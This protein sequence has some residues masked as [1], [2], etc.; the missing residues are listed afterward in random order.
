MVSLDKSLFNFENA[1][2]GKALHPLRGGP[3]G[4]YQ[5]PF[6]EN[7]LCRFVHLKVQ[8]FFSVI[9]VVVFN[10]CI[11]KNIFYH[12]KLQTVVFGHQKNVL[13]MLASFICEHILKTGRND[14]DSLHFVKF[15]HVIEKRNTNCSCKIK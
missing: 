14:G 4:S 13:H 3:E 2:A 5:E 12:F 6:L 7:V 8:H 1:K 15:E 10:N 9:S 11:Y